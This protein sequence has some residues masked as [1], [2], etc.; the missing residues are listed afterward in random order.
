MKGFV[1]ITG[2]IRRAIWRIRTRCRN[3]ILR[4]FYGMHIDKTALISV[5]SKLDK[6]YGAGVHIGEETTVASGAIIFT[7]DYC[8][9]LHT[10]TYVGKR[11]FI[12]ANAIIMAGVKIGDECVVGSGSIVTKDVPSNCMV[13]GNPA[14]I[15]KEGIKTGKYGKLMT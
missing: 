3:Y 5:G 10:D 4:L 12:G 15:I 13:A 7:H 1:A 2:L 6:T 11:C 9:N 14:R 8:R